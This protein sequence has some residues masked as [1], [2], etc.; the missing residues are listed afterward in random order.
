[1][2]EDRIDEL[3]AII[4][5][6]DGRNAAD[7]RFA[8]AVDDLVSTVYDDIG[9]IKN[10]STRALFDLFIIKVLYVG[11][12]SSDARV[13]DYLGAMLERYLDAREMYAPAPS[14]E[15]KP[16]TLYFSDMLDEEKTGERFPDRFGAYRRYADTALFV[17]GVFPASVSPSRRSSARP[18]RRRAGGIDSGYYVT[19]GKTMYRMAAHEDAAER[20][21]L[22]ETLLKL[23]EYFELYAGALNEMSERYILGFDMDLIA[24]KMLDCFNR[25]RQ[26]GDRQALANAQRYASV[27]RL[28]RERF[29]ALFA[30]AERTP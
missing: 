7:S 12:H 23:A 21:R 30:P 1:M 15:E 6:N 24:D 20:A 8:R 17:A 16:Q 3:K 18:P 26:T 2:L 9:E 10:I 11:R 28:D 13:L 25:Y 29:P 4:A 14:P 5:G 27:L 19:T 22:R